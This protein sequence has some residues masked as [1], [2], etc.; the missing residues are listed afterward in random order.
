MI[1]RNSYNEVK[2]DKNGKRYI[3][4]TFFPYLNRNENDIY[5]YT[6]EGDSLDRISKEYYG[7]EHYWFVI[8]DVNNLNSMNLEGGIQLRIPD[9]SMYLKEYKKINQ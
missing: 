4:D 3:E 6:V 1:N 7:N 9:L 2:K 8:A 5:I